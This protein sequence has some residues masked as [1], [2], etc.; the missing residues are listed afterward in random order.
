MKLLG[1]DVLEWSGVVA[2]CRISR[3]RCLTGCNG[4]VVG[5]SLSRSKTIL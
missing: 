3:E 4:R 5:F 1:E 2:N